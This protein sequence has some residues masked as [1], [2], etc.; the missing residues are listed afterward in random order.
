MTVNPERLALEL[1][2]INVALERIAVILER[3]APEMRDS[4]A[5]PYLAGLGDLRRTDPATVHEIQTGLESFAR[6]RG[7][8]LNSEAFIRSLQEFEQQVIESYGKEAIYDLPWNKAA[9]GAIFQSDSY[10]ESRETATQKGAGG[11]TGNAESPARSA[12][13]KVAGRPLDAD[14]AENAA[15][16][17]G[18]RISPD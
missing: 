13:Q 8:V 7:V 14:P 17:H 1:S 6:E 15:D 9:G 2:N 5:G 12:S 10:H 11:P 18:Y 16:P 4:Q 3:L